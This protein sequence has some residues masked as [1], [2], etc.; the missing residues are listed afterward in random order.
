MFYTSK[1]WV[2]WDF[3]HLRCSPGNSSCSV[4]G[5]Y[6]TG[7]EGLKGSSRLWEPKKAWKGRV[8]NE[9]V[10][11]KRLKWFRWTWWHFWMFTDTLSS[12]SM[13]FFFRPLMQVLIQACLFW[14]CNVIGEDVQMNPL[15]PGVELTNYRNNQKI[16]NRF[17][18]FPS[19]R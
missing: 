17:P 8:S 18:R 13:F 15:K 5:S 16:L 9:L 11:T 4:A 3:F 7:R 2:V 10:P 19:L 6:L 1:R 12:V 14:G